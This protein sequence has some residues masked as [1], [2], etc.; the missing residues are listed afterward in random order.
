MS[1]T[2]RAAVVERFPSRWFAAVATLALMTLLALPRP[3]HGAELDVASL[4]VRLHDTHAIGLVAKLEL[5]REIEQLIDVLADFH[6]GRTATSLDAIHG[7]FAV[8]VT[9]TVALLEPG[10]RELA[11]E[12]AVSSDDIWSELS[13]PSRFARLAK[14]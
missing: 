10:E 5:K 3:G 11:H 2:S 12:L 13:D 8:L 14:S 4:R 6:A 1:T 7:T 9:R